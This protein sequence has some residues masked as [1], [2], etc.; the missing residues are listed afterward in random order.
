LQR[1]IEIAF[2][3][4]RLFRNIKVKIQVSTRDFWSFLPRNVN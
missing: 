4:C 1:L 3:T 2:F